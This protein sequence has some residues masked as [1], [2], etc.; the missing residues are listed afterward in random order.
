MRIYRPPCLLR[1]IYTGAVFRL[2]KKERK[3]FLSF[4]DGP[5]PGVT[6]KIVDILV[7]KK[8]PATFFLSGEKIK[9]H[10]ELFNYLRAKKFGI[11]NHG[12]NH[13]NGFSNSYKQYI[14]DANQGAEISGS[15]FFRPA[16]GAITPRQYRKLKKLYVIVFWDLMPF[17]F[18]LKL[19]AEKVLGIIEKKIRPGAIIVLHDNK[20]SVS[21]EI[22]SR[23]IDICREKN[24]V[25]GDLISSL[26]STA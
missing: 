21:P 24:F 22:L 18:D 17:D 23:V 16:Y 19:K 6:E 20:K 5:T 13:I 26:N 8:A 1:Y 15:L 2:A 4:D 10:P 12:F 7:K 25:I 3:V 11:G 9:S 14:E